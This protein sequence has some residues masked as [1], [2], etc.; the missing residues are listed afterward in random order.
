MLQELMPLLAQRTLLL[1]MSRVSTDE[2]C[3]NI[4]PQRAKT[5]SGDENNA[6][7]TPLSLT[8]TPNELE[9][10]LP[11]QLVDFVAAHLSLSSTLRSAKE[12]ME[13]AA[14][15][16][17]ESSRK[18]IAKSSPAPSKVNVTAG[19]SQVSAAGEAAGLETPSSSPCSGSLFSDAPPLE[20]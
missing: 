13:A 11:G 5:S 16:A 7:T 18:S 17:R 12:Q 15:A 20:R 1:I 14:K 3:I 9:E 4:I 10:M 6:L 19:N 2:L 8:G